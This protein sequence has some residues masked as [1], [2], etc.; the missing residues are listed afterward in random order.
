MGVGLLLA[1]TL[2]AGAAALVARFLP[3]KRTEAE[4]ELGTP[5]PRL[6]ALGDPDTAASSSGTRLAA[7]IGGSKNRRF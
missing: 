4:A 5:E 3:A 6:S 7:C 2:T 1:A